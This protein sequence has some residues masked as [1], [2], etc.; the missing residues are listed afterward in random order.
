[1]SSPIYV[2]EINIPAYKSHTH[3]A[4]SLHQRSVLAVLQ[5]VFDERVCRLKPILPSMSNNSM[6][7]I[8][9]IF[10]GGENLI[11]RPIFIA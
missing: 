6:Q 2:Y 9:E 11:A 4:S 5:I 1:M 10:T 8:E 3:S 7:Q